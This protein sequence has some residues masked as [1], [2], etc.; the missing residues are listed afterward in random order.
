MD[1]WNEK[2]LR[3]MAIS[4]N[5]K[6]ESFF[7]EYDMNIKCNIERYSSKASEF[8]RLQLKSCAN[9]EKCEV[10]LFDLN[11]PDYEIGRE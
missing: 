2:E 5:D 10:I 7:D 4:G 1:S 8:Y 6:L 3:M 9:T 11:K